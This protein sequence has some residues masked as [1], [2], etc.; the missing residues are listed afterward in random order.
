MGSVRPP[1]NNKQRWSVRGDFCFVT[2]SILAS[3]SIVFRD[4]RGLQL[5]TQRKNDLKKK[6]TGFRLHP[7]AE[8]PSII[9]QF[10]V[11]R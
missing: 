4:K 3:D 7:I 1:D 10:K 9:L 11:R 6:R 8:V 5:I 2:V